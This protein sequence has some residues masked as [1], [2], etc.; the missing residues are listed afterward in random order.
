LSGDEDWVFEYTDVAEGE[1]ARFHD[2]KVKKEWQEKRAI[3]REHFEEQTRAWI[4][5]PDEKA[6]QERER[7]VIEYRIASIE[8]DPYLRPRT[9]YHRQGN[10][11][12][13]GT[14]AWHYNSASGDQTFGVPLSKMKQELAGGSDD[15]KEMDGTAEQT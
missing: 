9:V 3:L 7:A 12:E 5:S 1:N 4:Q 13:N 10:F 11:R 15:L 2:A 8:A 14:V 6:A